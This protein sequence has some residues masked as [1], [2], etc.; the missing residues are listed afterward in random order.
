MTSIEMECPKC[1]APGSVPR[2]RVHTRLVCKKCH[3]IFHLTSTGRTVLGEPPAE[4]AARDEGRAPATRAAGGPGG[5]GPSPRVLVPVAIAAGLFVLVGALGYGYVIWASSPGDDLA[6]RAKTTAEAIARESAP[7]VQAASLPDTTAD[8]SRFLDGTVVNLANI[9][10]KSPT[11]ELVANV[12]ILAITDNESNAQVRAVFT[13][14]LGS[15]RDQMISGVDPVQDV[16]AVSADV[17]LWFA[18]DNHGRWRL[19]GR[20]S[21]DYRPPAR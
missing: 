3:A 16:A 13:P 9:R 7:E 8:A 15:T 20:R 21:A 2:D 11:R 12:V 6:V 19:D 14:K 18:K 1:G 17:I 5:E 4:P 10:A